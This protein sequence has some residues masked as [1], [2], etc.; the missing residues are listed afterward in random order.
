M[1]LSFSEKSQKEIG[2]ILKKYPDKDA[3]LLPVLYVA[4]S[5]FKYIYNDVIDLIANYIQLPATRVKEVATFYT[6]YNKKPVGKYHL[7]F[8]NNI[9]CS[10]RNSR[11]LI[12]IVKNKLKIEIGETTSDGKFTLSTVECL[13][14][15]GTAPV[16]QVNNDYYENLTEESVL[17][18]LDS[19]K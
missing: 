6:M 19:L 7:Q 3:S 9:A 1:T 13:G 2:E 11:K 16:M 18:I 5:E 8:C 4:Q 15:C 17:K 14:A 12:E 10:L